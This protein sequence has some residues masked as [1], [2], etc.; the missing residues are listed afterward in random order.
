[1][2]RVQV[3]GDDLAIKIEAIGKLCTLLVLMLFRNLWEG[4]LVERGVAILLEVEA[5]HFIYRVDDPFHLEHIVGGVYRVILLHIDR[6]AA[7]VH[8]LS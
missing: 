1:M 4:V 5:L 8:I 7:V 3:R 6:I 2:M